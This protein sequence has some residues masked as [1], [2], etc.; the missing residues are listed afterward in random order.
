MQT[1]ARTG[2]LAWSL[3]K[4]GD[5]RTS[6]PVQSVP[7]GTCTCRLKAASSY[8]RC[9]AT[10]SKHVFSSDLVREGAVTMGPELRSSWASVHVM[11][12]VVGGST[13]D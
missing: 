8:P 4:A 3:E 12:Q 5:A 9:Q 2:A 10:P 11:L 7:K 1:S 13:P 6:S